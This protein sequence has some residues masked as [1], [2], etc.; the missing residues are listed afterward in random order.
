MKIDKT[1]LVL[2]GIFVTLWISFDS[3]P[4]IKLKKKA[5]KNGIKTARAAA[6][7]PEIIFAASRFKT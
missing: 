4:I 5:R 7:I 1:M 2:K 6:P 3:G